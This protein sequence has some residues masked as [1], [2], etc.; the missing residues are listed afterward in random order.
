VSTIILGGGLTGL[1]VARLV[2]EQGEEV[3]VLEKEREYGGLCRSK[4]VEGFTFDIGGSHIIFSR[5]SEVLAF[6]HRVLG[7][8]RTERHRETKILYKGRFV[9]Y[10]FENGLYELPKEDLFFCLN[11]Y[12]KTL[13]GVETGAIPLPEN[14]REWMYYTFGK[15]IAECYLVPYNE[16]IWNYPT[17][18]MSHHWVE[19]RIPRPPVEDVI[20]AAVGIPTEGYTH[21]VVFSYPQSGGIEALVHAIAKPVAGMVRTDF[22]VQSVERISG[23]WHVSDGREEVV[24]DTCIVTIPLQDLV[25]LLASIPPV[26][27]DAVRDLRYNSLITVSLGVKGSVPPYSWLYLPDIGGGLANRVSFPSNYST[28]VAPEGYGSVLAEV[29]WNEGDRVSEMTD[30]AVIADVVGSLARA[31]LIDPASVVHQSLFRQKYAYVV[32]D[33]MYLT[34]ITPIR[35]YFRQIGLPLVGRFAQFEYL[36]MDGCIRMAMDFVAGRAR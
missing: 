13:I 21:Q 23:R 5:D 10:P 22:S 18:K 31:G 14:F 32:Y 33:L 12:I 8:N 6:M 15:G 2:H 4:S 3:I 27:R 17:V 11:E 7:E 34:N 36:N 28:G 20:K 29:T 35:D 1:T 19:G 24:A 9:P 30:S 26:V 16:K 25:P